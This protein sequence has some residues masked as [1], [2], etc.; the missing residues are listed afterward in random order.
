MH[1]LGAQTPSVGDG[2][3]SE[4]GDWMEVQFDGFGRPLRNPVR[5]ISSAENK[6]VEVVVTCSRKTLPGETGVFS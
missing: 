3:E 6:P 2:I 5:V 4:D 1:F